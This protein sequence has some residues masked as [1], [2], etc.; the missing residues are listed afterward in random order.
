MNKIIKAATGTTLQAKSWLTEA[1]LRMLMNNLDPEVAERPQDL[2]VYGGIGKAARNWE[3]FDAIG[4]TLDRK[5]RHA[6]HR[7]GQGLGATHATEARRQ[8]PAPGEI[9]AVVLPPHLHK[10][11]VGALHDSLATDIDPRTGRHLAK[12]HQA[13]LIQ[14]AKVLPVRPRGHEV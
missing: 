5:H 10:R 7:G 2:V 9:P 11:L 3:C 13:F 4:L 6:R 12:H 14:L 1:P 8:N